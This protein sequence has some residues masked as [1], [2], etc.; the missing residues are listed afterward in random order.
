MNNYKLKINI[1]WVPAHSGIPGNEKAN[2]L[3]EK[4]AINKMDY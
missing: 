3:A 2:D 1:F 4:S